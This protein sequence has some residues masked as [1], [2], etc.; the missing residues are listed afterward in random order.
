[1]HC[2]HVFFAVLSCQPTRGTGIHHSSPWQLVLQVKHCLAHLC[3]CGILSFVAFI[4][5][6]LLVGE[7]K[8]KSA[9]SK[10]A[11]CIR[12]PRHVLVKMKGYNTIKVWLAPV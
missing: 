8:D 2:V 11:I 7:I 1:M 6:D 10:K 9:N 5:N 4:K 3:R 12:K